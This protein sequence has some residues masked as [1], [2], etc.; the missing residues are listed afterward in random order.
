ME[1]SELKITITSIKNLINMNK[2]NFPFWTRGNRLG[3]KT[4]ASGTC[5]TIIKDLMLHINVIRISWGAERGRGWKCIQKNN[6]C[7]LSKFSRRHKLTDSR[8]WENPKQNKPEEIHSTIHH[9]L[10]KTTNN[11]NSIFLTRN[12]EGQEKAAQHFSSAERK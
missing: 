10:L 3:E 9:E 12:Y 8:T 1:T 7:K 11:S 6:G 5:G 4:R 2:R